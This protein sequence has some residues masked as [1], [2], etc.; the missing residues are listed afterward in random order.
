MRCCDSGWDMMFLLCTKDDRRS[1]V[2]ILWP[3]LFTTNPFVWCL[4]VLLKERNL[5]VDFFYCCLYFPPSV[6]QPA[7]SCAV[8][9]TIC[10]FGWLV[11]QEISNSELYSSSIHL[12]SIPLT[13]L[14]VNLHPASLVSWLL[15]GA[16]LSTERWLTRA[17]N[18]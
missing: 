1:V 9:F 11:V 16:P 15:E 4:V 10:I 12:Q 14:L 6:A 13:V 17:T 2:E 3:V 8:L 7:L 5:T 18:I